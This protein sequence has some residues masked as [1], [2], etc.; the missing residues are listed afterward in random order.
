MLGHLPIG[1]PS[2]GAKH[3]HSRPRAQEPATG[4]GVDDRQRSV[5]TGGH[6]AGLVDD[7]ELVSQG[8]APR[9]Y[10][11]AGIV[12][13]ERRLERDDHESPAAIPVP[14]AGRREAADPAVPIVENG[15][16]GPVPAG[17]MIPR[18]DDRQRQ[19]VRAGSG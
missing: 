4:Q 2:E 18:S 1:R 7:V 8:M 16:A 14:E 3:R 5:T 6:P 12:T 13:R 19:L 17:P 9:H 10:R 11:Q 15:Q